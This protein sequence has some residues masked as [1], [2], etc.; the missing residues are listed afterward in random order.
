MRILSQR[1]AFNP[2]C[3]SGGT[4]YACS[5]TSA[6]PFLGCCA[7]TSDPCSLGCFAGN[8]RPA[9]FDP[10][11]WGTFPDG[12][13]PSTSRFYTC[14]DSTPPFLGCCKIN[15]CNAGCSGSD[16]DGAML[17][18]GSLAE[19]YYSSVATSSATATSQ[20]PNPSSS[21]TISSTATSTAD[22][23]PTIHK[24]Q[25]VGAIAGGAAG[26]V[27]LI[28]IIIGWLLYNYLYARRSREIKNSEMDRHN[29]PKPANLI[30]TEK[31]KEDSAGGRPGK[32]FLAVLF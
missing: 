23:P 18:A 13:C 9:S 16:L 6:Y 7:G 10:S 28:A 12:L 24:S 32:C 8:L 11:K 15:P 14:R 27:A 1:Q 20:P 17:P 21:S 3:P 31:P 26:G 25:N 4:W 29:T 30:M 5:N 2:S 19:A 22:Q